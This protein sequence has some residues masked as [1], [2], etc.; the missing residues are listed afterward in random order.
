M[1]NGTGHLDSPDLAKKFEGK[2]EQ[3][4]NVRERTD[5]RYCETR[6]VTL[7]KLP[8]YQIDDE[9]EMTTKDSWARKVEVTEPK[10]K[11]PKPDGP[12]K[13]QGAT[14]SVT[15]QQRLRVEK[16]NAAITKDRAALDD[17]MKL[18]SGSAAEYLPAPTKNKVDIVTKL[19]E[20]VIADLAMAAAPEWEG[21]FADLMGNMN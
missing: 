3:L 8:E 2:P 17:V 7:Y 20:V 21:S 1:Q 4:K 6:G 10:A 5:T 13:S 19:A 12:T 14:K 18:C 16:G 9:E 15:D 11:R